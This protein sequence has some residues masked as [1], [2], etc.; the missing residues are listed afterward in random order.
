[1]A[2]SAPSDDRG[3]VLIISGPSGVGKTTI[4][5]HVQRELGA[6]FSVSLTTREKTFRDADG[7]DYHFVNSEQFHKRREAGEF[8]EWADVHGNCYGTLAAPVERALAAGELII[9]EIDVQGAIQVKEKIPGA[10]AIFVLPPGEEELLRRLR[11]R[12]REGES[13]I[14]G[15]FAKAKHEIHRAR[16]C[17]AYDAFIVND[18]LSQAVDEAVRFVRERLC[19]ARDRRP[20]TEGDAP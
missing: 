8:L 12:A 11:D 20:P 18:D 3:M 6:R 10:F 9:L 2:E 4:K 19:G 5:D 13:D 14:Q 17:E 16:T 1:M 7:R 15:R